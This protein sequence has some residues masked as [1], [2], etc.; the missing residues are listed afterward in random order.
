M[1][2]PPPS[3]DFFAEIFDK[4]IILSTFVP[5]KQALLYAFLCCLMGACR[6]PERPRQKPFKRSAY[7][8]STTFE[9]DSANTDRL[10]DKTDRLYLRYFDVVLD[11]QGEPM[12]NATVRFRSRMPDSLEVV[13][14]VFIV[15][16][17]MK[18]DTKGLAG[19]ILRRTMQISETNGVEGVKELQIDCDWTMT[20]RKAYFE[21]L[22]ELRSLAMK[23]GLAL[24]TTIR[25]HQLSQPTPPVDR[26]VLMLY[27]TGDFTDLRQEKP[28]LDMAD[29][30]PYLHRLADY[31]LGLSTAYPMFGYRLLFRR[32]HY[33][34][35]LHEDNRLV[36]LPGD[37]I[38][39]R[40]TDPADVLQ[41]MTAIDG[42]R[43]D[44][45]RE[46]II[47][48]ISNRHSKEYKTSDYEKIYRHH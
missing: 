5:M 35:V 32:G 13:P 25:L 11:E 48:D 41:A 34:G 26:G 15:N 37:S 46:I 14:V 44:A 1:F 8:W 45:N 28:I 42:I 39:E 19:K 22:Q 38:V 36:K 6:A 24:S 9:T 31:K 27:N 47:Y 43:E 29:V 18:Q 40:R 2:Q 23:R 4:S 20:T 3:F 33:V 7:Y 30:A 10:L 21:F 16:D 12:P 17:V